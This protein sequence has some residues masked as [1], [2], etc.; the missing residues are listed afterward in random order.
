MSYLQSLCLKPKSFEARCI[1][2]KVNAQFGKFDV[3]R[4]RQFTSITFVDGVDH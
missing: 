2:G 4:T 1:T 3:R